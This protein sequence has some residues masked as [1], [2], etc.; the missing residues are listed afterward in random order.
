ME[1][2]QNQR[3]EQGSSINE[4]Q[5][6]KRGHS[7]LANVQ[8]FFSLELVLRVFFLYENKAILYFRFKNTIFEKY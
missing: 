1:Q 7:S 8:L 3:E 4:R 6:N 5:I 2:L